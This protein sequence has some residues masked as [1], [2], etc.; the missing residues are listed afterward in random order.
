MAKFDV[1]ALVEGFPLDKT[2]VLNLKSWNKEMIFTPFSYEKLED[3]K[4]NFEEI[5]KISNNR[6]PKNKIDQIRIKNQEV[7]ED[8]AYKNPLTLLTI[9]DIEKDRTMEEFI[10]EFKDELDYIL[11]GMAL[12]FFFPSRIKMAIF[13]RNSESVSFSFS[14]GKLH[15]EFLNGYNDK[16]EKYSFNPS[17]NEIIFL[18]KLSKVGAWRNKEFYENP[19]K[20][21][22]IL[23]DIFRCI[24]IFKENLR[25]HFDQMSSQM[26]GIRNFWTIFTILSNEYKIKKSKK[27]DRKSSTLKKVESLFKDYGM[28]EKFEEIKKSWETRSAWEHNRVLISVDERKDLYLKLENITRELIM[29]FVNRKDSEFS[30]QE[31]YNKND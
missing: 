23:P 25:N 16:D 21:K 18:S 28:E 2:L 5:I 27:K 19:G 7:L 9:K 17:Q 3:L 20:D 29:N 11:K 26:D 12:I 14:T 15:Y 4:N 6:L 1:F 10:K 8:L 22:V 30:K 24:S 13:I 31:K